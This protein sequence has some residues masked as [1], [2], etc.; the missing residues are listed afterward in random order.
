MTSRESEAPADARARGDA[1]LVRGLAVRGLSLADAVA[2]VFIAAIVGAFLSPRW[3]VG[4][5][6]IGAVVV[7]YTL[8]RGTRGQPV[9]RRAVAMMAVFA[10][11]IALAALLVNRGY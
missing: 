1:P 3:P 11:A 5:L 4:V 7:A 10:V 6:L 2:V 8:F 9:G